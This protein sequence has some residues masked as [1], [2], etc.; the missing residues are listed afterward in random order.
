LPTSSLGCMKPMWYY[1]RVLPCFSVGGAV[2][3]KLA[4]LGPCVALPLCRAVHAVLLGASI[5]VHLHGQRCR[6]CSAMAVMSLRV[7]QGCNC[8]A[9]ALLLRGGVIVAHVSS[10]V[11]RSVWGGGCLGFMVRWCVGTLSKN[12]GCRPNRPNTATH[13]VKSHCFSAKKKKKEKKR[14]RKK[15]K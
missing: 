9:G 15:E 5:V 4:S 10:V 12:G 3:R 8:K 14:K 1:G 11:S 6:C 13:T 7:G 2:V